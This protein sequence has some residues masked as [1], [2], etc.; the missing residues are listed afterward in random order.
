M[1]TFRI[2]KI[3]TETSEY[4]QVDRKK[5]FWWVTQGSVLTDGFEAFKYDTKKEARDFI[6]SL[7]SNT[8]TKVLEMA[9]VEIVYVK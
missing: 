7:V 9:F 5:F 6:K 4:F 8:K 2:M 3:R 1:E